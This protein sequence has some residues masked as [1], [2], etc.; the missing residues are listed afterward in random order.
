MDVALESLLDRADELLKDLEKEYEKCLHSKEVSERAKNITHEVL[1]KLR[2]A[3][4]Q[5]MWKAWDKYISPN[6]SDK[7]RE[8]TLVYFPITDDLNSFHSARG[9]G[10]WQNLEKRNKQLYDFL[11]N[12]QP[13][14]S[15]ENKW[16]CLLREI[17]AKGKHVRLAPQKRKESRRITVSRNNVGSVSWDQSSIRYAPGVSILGAPIDPKTQR[18]IP[19]P[20]VTEQVEIW[21]YF[22]FEGYNV[23]AFRFCEDACQ[24]TRKLIEDMVKLI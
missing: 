19:T 2:N 16:L 15:D 7:D 10:L 9:R 20:G 18:T 23:N 22:T 5:T 1:E 3:L 8:R 11:L 17:A 21:V 6:I 13:F 12:I 14:Y 24:K 4:D